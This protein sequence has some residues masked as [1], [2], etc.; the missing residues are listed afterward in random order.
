MN[1][2]IAILSGIVI[3]NPKV[4]KTSNDISFV[5]FCVSNRSG[6]KDANG[7]YESELFNCVA[8]RGTADIIGKY[9]KK[10]SKVTVSGKLENNKYVDKDG[11]TRSAIQ[12]NVT[13]IDFN[14]IERKVE[15]KEE[16]EKDD[17]LPF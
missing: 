1:T 5:S 12:I 9:V 6:K 11:E 7:E 14:S 8:W 17:N 15:A 16:S 10:G 13:E 2:N 3:A 4:M